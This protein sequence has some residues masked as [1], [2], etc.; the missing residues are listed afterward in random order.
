MKKLFYLIALAG[1]LICSAQ[2]QE[3]ATT[4]EAASIPLSAYMDPSSSI[5]QSAQKV[6]IDKMQKILSKNGLVATENERF[7]VT[8]NI[9]E[10]NVEKS[11]TAP[12]VY[13]VTL[14]VNFYLG[15]GLD[16][17]LY[18]SCSTEVSGAGE[19]KQKAYMAAVKKIKVNDPMFKAFL[20]KYTS[21]LCRLSAED[22]KECA[23]AL[24]EEGETYEADWFSNL[25]IN[26]TADTERYVS[27]TTYNTDFS[28][29][30]HDN[31]MSEAVTIRKS[32]GAVISSIFVE[33][34][35]EKMQDVLWKYLIASEEPE[36]PAEYRA[37][38]NR[39][40]EANYGRGNYLMLPTGSIYLAPDGVYILY[41]TQEICFWPGEPVIVIPYE[42][43]KPFLTKE[44]AQ[45]VSLE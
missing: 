24:A 5:P 44:A 19:S 26:K 34:A 6:M 40:L 20:D 35:E 7:I 31:R 21:T 9:N 43:A 1:T 3:P 10:L 11:E 2:A 12:V 36:D 33:D 39:F 14:E 27:Y 37:E 13:I 42:V 22:R 18:S 23:D 8:A 32:D 45:L 28:G 29:G 30:G 4:D 38:I 25:Y 17:I 41:S 16:A 15:D